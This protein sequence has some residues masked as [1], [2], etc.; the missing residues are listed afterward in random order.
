[1][2]VRARACPYACTPTRT[3]MPRIFAMRSAAEVPFQLRRLRAL[4]N[5]KMAT[6]TIATATRRA[7]VEGG[8]RDE[9]AG[10]RTREE[11]GM[12]AGRRVEGK[13]GVK[14]KF[15]R[16]TAR[17]LRRAARTSLNPN[18][19]TQNPKQMGRSLRDKRGGR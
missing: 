7:A 9:R 13:M 14:I 19:K 18:P 3:C 15:G 5:W 2:H 6:K 11:T 10:R 8:N 17:R 4:K 16:Q 1:M 12:G